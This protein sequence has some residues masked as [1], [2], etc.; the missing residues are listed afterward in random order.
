MDTNERK[1]APEGEQL[2]TDR[3]VC[4]PA[5]GKK[6]GEG[7]TDIDSDSIKNETGLKKVILNIFEI[8]IHITTIFK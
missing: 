1:E 8:T 4:P 3:A 5:E 6:H 2:P 7:H